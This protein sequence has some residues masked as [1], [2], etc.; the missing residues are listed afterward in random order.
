MTIVSPYP[1]EY[2][3]G[4]LEGFA[5]KLKPADSQVVRVEHEPGTR[6]SGSERTTSVFI[7]TW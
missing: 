7:V 2:E 5:R 3:H 6:P 1:D 4:V